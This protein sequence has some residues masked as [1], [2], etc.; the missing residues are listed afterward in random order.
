MKDPD[1]TKKAQSSKK[2]QAA[3]EL[4][5]FSLSEREIFTGKNETKMEVDNNIE[6]LS[7]EV[8][9]LDGG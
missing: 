7:N 3:P 8:N 9:E 2:W 5:C 6:S 1:P 4:Q